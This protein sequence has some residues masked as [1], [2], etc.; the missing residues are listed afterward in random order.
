MLI[1]QFRVPGRNVLV[2]SIISWTGG[3]IYDSRGL[4]VWRLYINGKLTTQATGQ[5]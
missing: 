1:E 4:S 3:I 2:F 5:G